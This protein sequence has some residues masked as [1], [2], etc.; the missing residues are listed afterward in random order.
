M[1]FTEV[2]VTESKVEVLTS[3]CSS[4][5][6]GVSVLEALTA[7]IIGKYRWFWMVLDGLEMFRDLG[8]M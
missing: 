8:E 1:D 7:S 2:L 3:R 4:L 5:H 6:L